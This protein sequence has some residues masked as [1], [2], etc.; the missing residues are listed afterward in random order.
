MD[1]DWV[2]QKENRIINH[3]LIIDDDQLTDILIEGISNNL[4]LINRFIFKTNGWKAL[5]YLSF[6]KQTNDFPNLIIL[7]LKMPEMTGYEFLEKYEQLYFED[8]LNTKIVIA[9]NS[10]L[11]YEKDAANSF[12]SI[13]LFINKPIV[14]EKFLYIYKTLFEASEN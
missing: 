14:K 4:N 6:C 11:K 7:D 12:P 10:P 13:D 9:T 2:L 5:E 8:F 3:L 1:E